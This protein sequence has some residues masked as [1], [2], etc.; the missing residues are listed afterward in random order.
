LFLPYTWYKMPAQINLMKLTFRHYRNKDGVVHTIF[1][2]DPKESPVC[3]IVKKLDE[4]WYEWLVKDRNGGFDVARSCY[5][6][7]LV[8][9][10][11]G[12]TREKAIRQVADYIKKGDWDV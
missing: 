1:I 12:S 4:G 6:P 8:R 2:G 5:K 7:S 9:C 11:Y 3:G 10:G